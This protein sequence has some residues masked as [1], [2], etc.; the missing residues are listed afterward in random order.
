MRMALVSNRYGVR[1]FQRGALLVEAL[2]VIVIIGILGAIALPSMRETLLNSDLVSAQE[3]LATT[4][5]RARALA[6]SRNAFI[7]VS[8]KDNVVTLK[9]GKGDA[10]QTVT[11]PERTQ[12]KTMDDVVFSPTGALA[13]AQID[14][15]VIPKNG[16]DGKHGRKIVLT[17]L[18]TATVDRVETDPSKKP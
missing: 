11:L 3:T 6:K 17:R 15:W 5:D 2:V 18:G 16:D 10:D 12:V 14:I 1:E 9:S 13:E 8:V 4:L 7:T